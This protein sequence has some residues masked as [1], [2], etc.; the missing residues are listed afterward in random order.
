MG[1][2]LNFPGRK[3]VGVLGETTMFE[4]VVGA[5]A[6]DGASE[7]SQAALLRIAP[8]WYL[9]KLLTGRK[10]HAGQVFGRDPE[11]AEDP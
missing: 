6:A 11:T 10:L 4:F 8:L 1:E 5:I 7:P 9:H 2:S 3:H